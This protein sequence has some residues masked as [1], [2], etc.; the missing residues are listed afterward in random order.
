MSPEQIPPSPELYVKVRSAFILRYT[1]FHTWCKE[2]GIHQTN[3][4]ACLIGLWDGPKGKALRARIIEAS[5]MS[6]SSPI[7]PDNHSTP[8]QAEATEAEE[9]FYWG[10]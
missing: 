7:E 4:K 10:C 1:T 5:G 8:D 9:F 2:E 3:A 6:V